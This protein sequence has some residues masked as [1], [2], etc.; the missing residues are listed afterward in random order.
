VK[1]GV[2]FLRAQEKGA[3]IGPGRVTRT[4]PGRRRSWSR[5]AKGSSRR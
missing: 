2:R 3:S 1:Q 5:N 4:R